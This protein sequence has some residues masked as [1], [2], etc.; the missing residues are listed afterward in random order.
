MSCINSFKHFIYPLF[1]TYKGTCYLTVII[2]IGLF[3]FGGYFRDLVRPFS[4]FT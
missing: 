2:Y 1:N 4:L 3:I